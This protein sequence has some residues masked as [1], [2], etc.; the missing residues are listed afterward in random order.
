MNRPQYILEADHVRVVY[1]A[2]GRSEDAGPVE[3]LRGVDLVVGEAETVVLVEES[4]SGKSTLMKLFNRLVGP[5]EGIVKGHGEDVSTQDPI[6]LRRHIGTIQQEGAS[7]PIGPSP[8]ISILSSPFLGGTPTVAGRS[9]VSC[10]S[11]SDFLSGIREPL[12]TGAV[13]RTA[14]TGCHRQDRGARD[15]AG[16]GAAQG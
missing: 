4:G 9:G 12:P 6:R 11:L 14:A 15:D 2:T 10:S 8:A 3:A 1:P 5:A 7:F 16:S 13:G